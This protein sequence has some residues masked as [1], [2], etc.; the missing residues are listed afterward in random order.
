MI[1][2]IVRSGG[3]LGP[4]LPRTV[5][6][7]KCAVRVERL[8]SSPPTVVTAPV[9]C[10]T[11]SPIFRRANWLTALLFRKKY[12]VTMIA[13]NTIASAANTHPRTLFHFMLFLKCLPQR[14][15]ILCGVDAGNRI[16]VAAKVDPDGAD[17]RGVAKSDADGVRVIVD[18]VRKINRAVNIAPVVKDHA[19][20]RL[21]DLKRKS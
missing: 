3:W 15:E 9:L 11:S 5:M 10:C 1:S 17:R 14:D 18:K 16:E 12:P 21:H 4:S 7:R 2:S 6:L 8:K 19:A 13:R 20:Q